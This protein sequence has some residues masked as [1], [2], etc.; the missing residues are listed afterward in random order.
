MLELLKGFHL[1]DILTNH[2][3][4]PVEF[5]NIALDS[6]KAGAQRLKNA[7]NDIKTACEVKEIQPIIDKNNSYIQEFEKLLD[8]YDYEPVK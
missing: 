1:T 3:R 6:A 5:N 2:Y 7:V 8:I 4:Q